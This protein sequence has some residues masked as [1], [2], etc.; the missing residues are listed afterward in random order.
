MAARWSA[1]SGRAGHLGRQLGVALHSG[2]QSLS[3][4]RIGIELGENTWR[5]INNLLCQANALC[6]LA[7]SLPNRLSSMLSVSRGAQW[8]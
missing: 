1:I 5:E 8:L 4:R 6:L 7:E 3:D 2:E